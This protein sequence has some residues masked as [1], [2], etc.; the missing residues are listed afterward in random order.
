M[1][2]TSSGCRIGNKDFSSVVASIPDDIDAVYVA[3]G[4][5]DAVNFLTQYEQAGG[6]K[7]MIG[8]SITVDQTVLGSKG[9]RR[10][11]CS[12]RPR[13]ARS[14]TIGTTRDGRRSSPPTRRPSRTAS[15]AL[16]VRP[17][18]LHRSLGH[19]R[20]A[21][22]GQGRSLRRPEGVPRG[23]G[24]RD[25][26]HARPARSSSTRTAT[27]S[28]TSSSPKWRKATDGNLYNKVVKV[29]PDG[30]SD[31]GHAGGRV[32]GVGPRSAAT[33]PECP[34]ARPAARPDGW[35]KLSDC[36]GPAAA[37]ALVLEGVSREL[38]RA[39]RP[40]TT[41]TLTV[42]AGERRGDARRQRRGQDDPVQRHHRRFP[43]HRR[44]HPLLRRGRDRICRPTSASAA[45]CGAP[46]RTRMLFRGLSVRDNLFLA[47]RG[48][49]RGRFSFLRPRDGRRARCAAPTT[50]LERVRLDSRR[51]SSSV[52]EL[53]PRP[54]APARDRHGAG[55]RAAPASCS[56]SRPPGCRR[57]SG[58]S[59]SQLLDALPRAHRLHPHRAR[60]RHRAARGRP[61][62]RDAQR[63]R[64]SS[65]A[66][67]RRSRTTPR[68]RRIYMGGRPPWL[69]HRRASPRTTAPAIEIAD[70]DVYY[71]HAHALQGVSLTL[72]RGVLGVVGRNGMGK[73]TLCNAIMGLVPA[74]AGSIRLAGDEILGLPPNEI[75][76]L[77]HR[78]R[79]AG[80]ARLALAHGRRAS[81]PGR[82]RRQGALDGRAHLPD[83]PAPGRAHGA[84]AAPSSPAASSR[85]WPSAARCCSIRA[86]W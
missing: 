15:R 21:R 24:E 51:A 1:S 32:P 14:P 72:D 81:A 29:D 85:C 26:R 64:S 75:V 56:T 69:I 68:C 17:W 5:A 18:L 6:D 35:P 30:G 11:Y 63:P 45:A 19:A 9:K 4:G 25:R 86:C 16:A 82:Q 43:A 66:R 74:R 28:P 61:R 46:I 40:S 49:T 22:R 78:L 84:T 77:R 36:S 39:R 34:V 50:S 7:P 52:A 62:D 38:R 48:V 53:S 10:D 33:N 65:T 58:A 79:A 47:A 55:R 23:A 73:T 80:A 44:A 12:A 27:P 8:G 59:W 3:L 60:P 71:G 2:S 37:H 57:P 42:A 41:S 83:L 67:R 31:P 70:L 54:A 20:G 13:P 76:N